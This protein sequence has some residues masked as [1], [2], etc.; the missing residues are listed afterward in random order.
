MRLQ[1]EG[2]PDP[3]YRGNRQPAGPR[4]AARTPMR[5]VGRHALQ[6]PHD[7]RLDPRILDRSRRTRA[8][9]IPQTVEAMLDE[10]PA[11]LAD[12]RPIDL[13]PCRHLLVLR[14]RG[15]GQ[16]DPGPQ[17]QGLR[18]A[19]PSCQRSQLLAFVLAQLQGCQSPTRHRRPRLTNWRSLASLNVSAILRT[20]DS[21][22]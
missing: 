19:A 15:A 17:R 22:H 4:H 20:S 14:P 7:H 6:C 5:G 16:H 21:G 3:L 2:A 8:G 10:A 13:K 1:A 18:R 11:P 9:L 12:R